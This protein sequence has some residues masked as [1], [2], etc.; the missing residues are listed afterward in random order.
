MC[1]TA[2][3][4]LFR[5]D[6]MQPKLCAKCRKNIAVVFITRIENGA[7]L[8]EGYCLK[9]ARSLGVPQIDQAVKQMGIS[10][11]DLDLLSD[12]MS[13]MFGQKDSSDDADGDEWTARLPPSP[14]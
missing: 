7:T 12:E 3:K 5:R 11:E 14:C 10:E 13:S 8:N 1:Y 9:C 4:G 2:G 6:C